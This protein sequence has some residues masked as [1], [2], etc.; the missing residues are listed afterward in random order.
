MKVDLQIARD[1]PH[2]RGTPHRHINWVKG[3]PFVMSRNGIL[4]HRLKAA[5]SHIFQGKYSH[6]SADYWCGNGGVDRLFF[7]VPPEGR[8]VCAR[9]EAMAIAAGEKSSDELVGAHVHIGTL[10]AVRTCCPTEQN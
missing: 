1:T 10:R 7:A 5:M 6:D 4:V 3:L 2:F 9:C 8:I